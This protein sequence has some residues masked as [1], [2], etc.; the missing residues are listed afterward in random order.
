MNPKVVSDWHGG[1][2]GKTSSLFFGYNLIEEVG[3]FNKH[4][5]TYEGVAVP[6]RQLLQALLRL[7]LEGKAELLYYDNSLMERKVVAFRF[8]SEYSYDE[9]RDGLVEVGEEKIERGVW[10]PLRNA[11][12]Y[13]KWIADLAGGTP[14]IAV[15]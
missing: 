5:K 15:C 9:Y 10:E 12:Q 3:S 14:T 6:F 11:K 1:S 8:T 7:V 13:K 4:S 2:A